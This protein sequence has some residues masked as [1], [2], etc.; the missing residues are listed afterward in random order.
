MRQNC[1]KYHVDR[2]FLGNRLDSFYTLKN[3]RLT[4]VTQSALNGFMC[5]FLYKEVVL[6]TYDFFRKVK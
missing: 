3:T 6:L 2:C 1:D 4:H 5:S